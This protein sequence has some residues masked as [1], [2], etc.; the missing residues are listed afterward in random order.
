[1][2]ILYNALRHASLSGSTTARNTLRETLKNK[3]EAGEIPFLKINLFLGVTTKV[4]GTRRLCT[5]AAGGGGSGSVDG[6]RKYTHFPCGFGFDLEC[7]NVRNFMHALIETSV[8]QLLRA[9]RKL[10]DRP[11][12]CYQNYLYL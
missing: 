7:L 10:V 1:M 4:K 2:S 5:S 9:A 6:E 3:N 12:I 11:S 8:I